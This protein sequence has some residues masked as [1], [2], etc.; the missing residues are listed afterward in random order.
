MRDAR[1]QGVEPTELD[2]TPREMIVQLIEKQFPLY[3]YQEQTDPVTGNVVSVPRGG[4]RGQPEINRENQ[5][6]QHE[7]LNKVADLDFP[8]N[9]LDALITRFGVNHVRG[10]QRPDAPVGERPIRAAQATGRETAAS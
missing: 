5:R 9:P 4:C 2:A 3:Q 1:A 7:L 6:R 10:N 8:H